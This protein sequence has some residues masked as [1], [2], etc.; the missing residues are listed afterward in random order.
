MLEDSDEENDPENPVYQSLYN[1]GGLQTITQMTTF[2]PQ[3]FVRLWNYIGQDILSQWKVG[4]GRK[5][6][7]RAKDTFFMLLAVVKHGGNRDFLAR[8][9]R[10]KARTFERMITSVL[11]IISLIVYDM[12]VL[13]NNSI[14]TMKGLLQEGK[15]F[16]NFPTARYAADVT[17]Q[18]YF[19]PQGTREDAKKYVSGKHKLYSLKGE[20]SVNSLGLAIFCSPH[21][22]GSVSY[23]DI[24][25]NGLDTRNY[26]LS[27]KDGELNIEDN[28]PYKN[29][30]KT[31]SSLLV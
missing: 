2:S 24:L 26:L 27:M 7:Y 21:F 23:I 30:C 16:K 22:P 28:G 18:Q 29:H 12:F 17:F 25:Y 15:T 31:M 4:C 5:C 10:I 13:R 19:R 11:G 9:F 3:E 6:P 1:V 8:M 20:V 14:Y